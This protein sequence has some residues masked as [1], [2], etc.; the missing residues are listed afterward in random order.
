MKYSTSLIGGDLVR[1]VEY[2]PY[3]GSLEVYVTYFLDG[4]TGS[5]AWAFVCGRMWWAELFFI[6]PAFLSLFKPVIWVC[7][8]GL[9]A[10]YSKPNQLPPQPLAKAGVGKGCI[11]S[12]IGCDFHVV[13]RG[14]FD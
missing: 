3:T 11:A 4:W 9:R 6:G 10:Y 5:S 12:R 2:F 13:T 14:W 7:V 8:L 1:E